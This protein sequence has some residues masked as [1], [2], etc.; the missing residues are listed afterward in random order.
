MLKYKL[1]LVIIMTDTID[2][3]PIRTLFGLCRI[4][5]SVLLND[6]I[7]LFSELIKNFLL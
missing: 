6:S 3:V 5:I 1:K 4:P 2:I 7:V